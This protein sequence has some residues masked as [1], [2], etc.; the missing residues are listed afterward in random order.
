MA[1]YLDY[2]KSEMKEM[3]DLIKERD[4]IA[5]ELLTPEVFVRLL[6]WL[7]EPEPRSA[8]VAFTAGIERQIAYLLEMD[9]LPEIRRLRTAAKRYETVRR[10]NPRARDVAYELNLKT[11]KPFD[12]IIDEV[13]PFTDQR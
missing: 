9:I 7:R 6:E 5:Q 10:M 8:A 1:T 4:Q 13:R 12:E 3:E 2:T 11:G